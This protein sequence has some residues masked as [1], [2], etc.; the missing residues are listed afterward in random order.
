MN[1]SDIVIIAL[2]IL[3][4]KQWVLRF[5]SKTWVKYHI[6]VKQNYNFSLTLTY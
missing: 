5:T 3:G 4:K 2:F 1:R 6:E